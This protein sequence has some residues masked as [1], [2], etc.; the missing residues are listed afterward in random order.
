MSAYPG[1][2]FEKHRATG[3]LIDTN[4]MLLLVVGNYRPQRVLTFK[5]TLQYT[6]DDFDLMTRLVEYFKHR[7]TTPNILTEVDNLARQL[8]QTE[9]HAVATTMAKIVS[10][11]FEI[12]LPSVDAFK[13]PSYSQIGLSDSITAQSAI[14]ALVVTDDFRLSNKLSSLGRDVVNINHIRTL[15]WRVR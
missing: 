11:L 3:V 12:Y 8:P 15:G 4:L 13:E 6:L 14:E 5:R 1:S 9:H 7:F 10:G 2:L